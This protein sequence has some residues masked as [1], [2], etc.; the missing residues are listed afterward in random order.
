MKRNPL[1]GEND[2]GAYYPSLFCIKHGYKGNIVGTPN[3]FV[4]MHEYIHFLQDVST[5]FGKMNICNFYNSVRS[6]AEYIYKN[7][8]STIELPVR[9][10][11]LSDSILEMSNIIRGNTCQIPQGKNKASFTT[12]L[13]NTKLKS[14]K[15]YIIVINK[16]EYI[17][18]SDDII[19]N[20]AYLIEREIYGDNEPAPPYPYKTIEILTEQLNP[21]FAK[22]KLLIIALCELSLMSS[23]PAEF[24]FTSL[25]Q[26]K[27]RNLVINQIDDLLKLINKDYKL[28][29]QGN[30]ISSEE[31]NNKST[32]DAISFLSDPFKAK[33]Y[34]DLVSWIR[35]VFISANSFRK[36]DPFFITKGLLDKNPVEYYLMDLTQKIG[37]P[38]I[39]NID[40]EVYL[41]EK[42]P[43]SLILFHAFIEFL[44]IFKYGEIGCS[45]YKGCTNNMK[46][47][48]N[49]HSIS[50]ECLSEP[51]KKSKDKKLCPLGTLIYIWGLSDVDYVY[52]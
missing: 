32:D 23:N 22:N 41:P 16:K 9:L 33:E 26:I 2:L 47:D 42:S 48:P 39:M 44:E 34:H 5:I 19:E 15:S 46:F 4:L 8:D 24:Y 49:S 36:N 18:G 50:N 43:Q 13:I 45:M 30:E 3:E 51:W 21:I 11:S 40:Q 29:Y 7:K 25:Q 38:P 35:D 1:K 20:M 52:K 37:I 31:A 28:F 14:I 10:S 12:K 6:I 17:V 27:N